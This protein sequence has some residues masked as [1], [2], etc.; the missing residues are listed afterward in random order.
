MTFPYKIM[1]FI[2]KRSETQIQKSE[3]SFLN[4][5]PQILLSN[6]NPL[7]LFCSFLFGEGS[8][9]DRNWI[10][11]TLPTAETFNI[12]INSRTTDVNLNLQNYSPVHVCSFEAP[13]S[14]DKS[15]YFTSYYSSSL[16]LYLPS[17]HKFLPY[18]YTTRPVLPWWCM[19][20][21][22]NQRPDF[23]F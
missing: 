23:S 21:T 10:S 22:Q 18:S 16:H 17:A 7:Y 8:P 1:A 19:R 12:L 15:S 2:V 5:A 11:I 13:P 4:Q 3:T 6:F 9:K 14:H 20:N